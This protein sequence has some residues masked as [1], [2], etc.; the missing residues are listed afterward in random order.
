MQISKT[1]CYL[2]NYLKTLSPVY[3]IPFCLIYKII[4]ALFAAEVTKTEVHVKQSIE[5]MEDATMVT[6]TCQQ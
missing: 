4:N 6:R 2:L 3:Q 5:K 1:I